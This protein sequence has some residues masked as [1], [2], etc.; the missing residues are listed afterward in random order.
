MRWRQWWG[1]SEENEAYIDLIFRPGVKS[2]ALP[3]IVFDHECQNGR[4]RDRDAHFGYV[5]SDLSMNRGTFDAGNYTLSISSTPPSGDE[6]PS[7][8]TR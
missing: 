3:T 4:R 2:N 6:G 8:L 7:G 5:C 1:A